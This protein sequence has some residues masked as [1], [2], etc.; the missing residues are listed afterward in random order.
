MKGVAILLLA[1]GA[2][3]RMAGRDKL[4]ERI[5]D[6][7]LIRR[8]AARAKATGAHLMVTLPP[9]AHARRAAVARLNVPLLSVADAAEGM[10][11]SI[12]AGTAAA[13]KRGSEGLMIL[14]A[15]MPEITT[16]DMAGMIEAFLAT[17]EP[18]PILRA[19][20][21]DGEPGHPVILPSRL[22]GLLGGLRGD[23][24]ARSILLDRPNDIVAHPLPGDHALVDL[25]TPED[26]AAWRRAN[27]QA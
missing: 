8:Q 27:P 23:V 6:T 26:W 19:T 9:V 10:A 22:F 18:R 5:D 17:P 20:S 24:G 15:D 25:D 11:A 3:R 1:A 21:A 7:P 12:R 13:M 2:A 14:P 16:E 4:M